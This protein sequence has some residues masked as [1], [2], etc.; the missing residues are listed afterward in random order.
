MTFKE[1][2]IKIKSERERTKYRDFEGKY[3]G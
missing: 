3:T 1:G 2:K